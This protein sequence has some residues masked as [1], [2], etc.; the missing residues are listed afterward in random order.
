MPVI[1]PGFLVGLAAAVQHAS[2]GRTEMVEVIVG[3]L[4]KLISI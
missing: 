1:T 4:V 3:F 2:A